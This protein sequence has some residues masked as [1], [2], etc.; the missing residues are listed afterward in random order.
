MDEVYLKIFTFVP[1]GAEN[2]L[3]QQLRKG[4]T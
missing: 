4:K 1:R 3:A 2:K